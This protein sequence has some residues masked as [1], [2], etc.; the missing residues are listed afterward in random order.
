MV[1]DHRGHFSDIGDTDDTK[2]LAVRHVDDTEQ[3]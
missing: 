3:R 2:P 1:A